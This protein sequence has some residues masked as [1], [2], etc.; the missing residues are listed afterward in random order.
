MRVVRHIDI[1]SA[2]NETIPIPLDE[3]GAAG[4]DCTF[5]VANWISLAL[6]VPA[7]FG[8]TG[9]PILNSQGSI[10][11]AAPGYHWQI[12]TPYPA[13]ELV[14]GPTGGVNIRGRINLLDEPP[15]PRGTVCIF[16]ASIGPI[17]PAG[18][19]PFGSPGLGSLRRLHY[20]VNMDQ[21]FTLIGGGNYGQDIEAGFILGTLTAVGGGVATFT[22]DPAP[23]FEQSRVQNDAGA[24]NM[25]GTVTL[26]GEL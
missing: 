13:L 12:P 14:F 1:D 16:V 6:R 25:S 7:A 20:I 2:G 22:L 21:P 10:S 19:A 5:W 11:L 24:G 8:G 3:A 9:D 4:I 18:S 26:I 15:T 23:L 17:P